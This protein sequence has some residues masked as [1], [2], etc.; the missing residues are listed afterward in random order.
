MRRSDVGVAVTPDL[1]ADGRRAAAQCGPDRPDGLLLPPQIGDAD[2]LLLGQVAVRD[3]TRGGLQLTPARIGCEPA[4]SANEWLHRGP[5]RVVTALSA[6]YALS[7]TVQ[8]LL[9]GSAV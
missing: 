3:G 9:P 8:P 6:C 4:R 2:A 7:T 1:T 5:D